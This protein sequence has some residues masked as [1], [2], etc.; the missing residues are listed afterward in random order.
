MAPARLW[1]SRDGAFQPTPHLETIMGLK[2]NET[3]EIQVE[4]KQLVE[5]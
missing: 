3:Y 4:V 1:I 5:K 2:M